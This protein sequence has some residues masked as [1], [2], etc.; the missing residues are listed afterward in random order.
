MR[1]PGFDRAPGRNAGEAFRSAGCCSSDRASPSLSIPH[2]RVW[3]DSRPPTWPILKYNLVT[4]VLLQEADACSWQIIPLILCKVGQII[5]LFTEISGKRNLTCS[6][7][8][9]N[10]VKILAQ[11]W[12]KLKC[13]YYPFNTLFSYNFNG[14]IFYLVLQV[15]VS[16]LKNAQEKKATFKNVATDSLNLECC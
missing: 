13:I 8:S 6:Y 2:P 11:F 9:R 4:R 7:T 3:Q 16:Y 12:T 5:S 10:K 14:V 1:R 15:K